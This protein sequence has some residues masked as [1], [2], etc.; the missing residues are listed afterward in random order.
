[1]KKKIA[2]LMDDIPEEM[3]A[4]VLDTGRKKQKGQRS[5]RLK[6]AAAA[7]L[8]LGLAGGGIAYAAAKYPGFFEKYLQGDNAQLYEELQV[9]GE[10]KYADETEDYRMEVKEILA[11]RE[12]NKILIS[13]EALNDR[14][15]KIMEAGTVVPVPGFGGDYS[16]TMEKKLR[17]RTRYFLIE[18]QTDQ[19]ICQVSYHPL[20]AG[21]DIDEEWMED[22]KEEILTVEFP[23]KPRAMETITIS[24]GVI[25]EGTD[26]SSITLSFMGIKG[27]APV[28]I[29]GDLPV[30]R[31]TAVM[32]DGRQICLVEG[33][34]G[35]SG[36]EDE[37]LEGAESTGGGFTG[38]GN[39]KQGQ[40]R[41]VKEFEEFLDLESID[42]VLVNN[43][44]YWSR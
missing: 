6:T 15:A 18:G 25:G 26:Y 35:V 24:P 28:K 12:F 5:G 20:M 38:K 44:E 40:M 19:E 37:F 21:A 1:M 9:T 43:V 23:V 22:H 17:E 29:E 16:V 32:A 34:M 39:N 36:T 27:E 4:E 2:D 11:D 3:L 30:P 10:T 41:Y 33:N 42:R 14:S 31:V 13:V 7:M 8:L